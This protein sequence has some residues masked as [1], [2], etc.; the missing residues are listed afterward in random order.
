MTPAHQRA[1]RGPR[2]VAQAPAEEEELAEGQRVGGHHPL[3]VGVGEPEGC[4]AEGR[5]M[6]MIVVSSTT[7]SCAPWMMTR[8]H[9]PAAP[10]PLPAG[11][12]PGPVASH[13]TGHDAPHVERAVRAGS[14]LRE[15]RSSRPSSR[16]QRGPC[17]GPAPAFPPGSFPETSLRLPYPAPRAFS[18]RPAAARP[19]LL[20]AWA[21]MGCM[22]EGGV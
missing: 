5:A 3:P 4:R 8:I 17:S 6:I 11:L 2:H 7:M 21:T 1:P 9:Q 22:T 20:C 10:F 15:P 16:Q 18:P 12:R 14:G 13:R 19:L